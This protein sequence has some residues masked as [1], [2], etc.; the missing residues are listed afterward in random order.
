MKKIIMSIIVLIAM[1][2]TLNVHAVEEDKTL[3]IILPANYFN[4]ENCQN[5]LT[6]REKIII[7]VFSSGGDTIINDR[8]KEII[9]KNQSADEQSV[10]YEILP[11]VTEEDR[12]IELTQE[13]IEYISDPIYDV[14]NTYPVNDNNIVIAKN[15]TTETVQTIPVVQG[16]G[17]YNI[18][19]KEKFYEVIAG[20]TKIKF[21]VQNKECQAITEKMIIDFKNNPNL[22]DLSTKL[23][24]I[25]YYLFYTIKNTSNSYPIAIRNNSN[26]TSEI[27]K[28]TDGKV[29]FTVGASILEFRIAP[30]LTYLDNIT[31]I[32]K[33]ED[34][35]SLGGNKFIKE[36]EFRFGEE[37]QKKPTQD[38]VVEI[39]NTSKTLSVFLY[40]G[41]AS[42]IIL[43]SMAIVLGIDKKKKNNI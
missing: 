23:N 40:I 20:Y 7:D 34:Y 16:E 43:G 14:V 31:V 25:L 2:S 17:Y 10:Y 38:Q 12:T 21:S 1:I 11:N 3:E 29:L 9:R 18:N 24:D 15:F 22:L 35:L 4:N 19:K 32:L 26:G 39:P 13:L 41:S 5:N 27:V 36:I 42:L 37:P 30:N 6:E 33:E 28:N 8:N